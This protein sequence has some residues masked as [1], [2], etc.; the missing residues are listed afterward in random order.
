MIKNIKLQFLFSLFLF[1]LLLVVTASAN[2]YS[3]LKYGIDPHDSLLFDGENN[4]RTETF[5]SKS[6]ED[7]VYRV[8]YVKGTATGKIRKMQVIDVCGIRKDT[9][10]EYQNGAIEKY[11]VI[12]GG[13]QVKTGPESTAKIELSDGSEII[14]GPNTNYTLPEN[15]C[16]N[17]RTGFLDCGSVWTKVKKMIG[18]GKFE[19]TTERAVHGVRGTE[20]TVE[21]I[22]ENGIK[23]DIIKVYEGSVEVIL[24]NIDDKSYENYTDEQDKLT[25]DFKSGKITWEEFSAKLEEMSQRALRKLTIIEIKAGYFLKTDVGDPSPFNTSEDTW[26]KINE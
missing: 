13:E 2:G 7:C 22:E 18:G 14:L 8:T 9:I 19:V 21:I 6:G 26:F 25:E 23:Y 5:Y 1:F 10:Y 24:K 12:K 15:V 11:S 16:D 4:V 3:P 17:L 20:F